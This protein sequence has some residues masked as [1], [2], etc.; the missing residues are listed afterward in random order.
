MSVE[1]DVVTTLP[2]QVRTRKGDG[3]G[4]DAFRFAGGEMGSEADRFWTKVLPSEAC[5]NWTAMMD[6]KGY[7]R[8][9]VCRNGKWITVLAHRWAWEWSRW[10]IPT[11]LQ[12]DH[13]CRNPSCV[14][15][16]HMELVVPRENTLRGRGPSA[17][18]AAKTHCKYGHALSGDNLR[19]RSDRPTSRLCRICSNLMGR[20]SKR[21]AR[22]EGRQK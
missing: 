15:A 20:N 22:A 6:R 17:V 10:P 14:N 19:R 16:S 18:N 21:R 9:V 12:I 13:L 1:S 8:F 3:I 7:G 5:L 4:L 2:A 11:G